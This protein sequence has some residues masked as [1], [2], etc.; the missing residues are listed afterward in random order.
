[1]LILARY[2][3]ALQ[4]DVPMNRPEDKSGW[5]GAAKLQARIPA[6]EATDEDRAKYEAT[7][8]KGKE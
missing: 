1:M 4:Q 6:I 5:P 8:K 2:M 7:L 3:L